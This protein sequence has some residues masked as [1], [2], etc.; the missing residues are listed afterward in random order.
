MENNESQ[1]KNQPPASSDVKPE[2]NTIFETDETSDNKSDSLDVNIEETKKK[3][4]EQQD[5]F[6]I[7]L[8]TYEA[9]DFLDFVSTRMSKID[10]EI[11]K[12]NIDPDNLEEQ[13]NNKDLDDLV[14]KYVKL[15]RMTDYYTDNLSFNKKTLEGANLS[16]NHDKHKIQDLLPH[17]DSDKLKDLAN[18]YS[19]GSEDAL[20]TFVLVTEGDLKNVFLMNS[21]FNVLIRDPSSNELNVLFN[22]LKDES[23]QYG[24]M[25]GSFFYLFS[26]LYIKE[27]IMN[28]IE[29]HIVK[30]NLKGWKKKGIIRKYLSVLDY[31][32]LLHSMVSLMFPDGYDYIYTCPYQ[33]CDYTEEIKIDLNK[34]KYFNLDILPE[35]CLEIVTSSKEFDNKTYQ[36]YQR[37]L[38]FDNDVLVKT[39]K[40]IYKIYLKVPTMEEYL[41]YGKNYNKIMAETIQ[42]GNQEQISNY[43]TYNYLKIFAPWIKK[44]EIINSSTNSILLTITDNDVI[45]T[46]LDVIQKKNKDSL[47]DKIIEFMKNSKITHICYPVNPCPKCKRMPTGAVNGFLPFDIQNNFFFQLQMYLIQLVLQKSP[48]KN[49]STILKS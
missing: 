20:K 10:N 7:A 25:F 15:K 5:L 26:D 4:K 46:I 19:S 37:S 44:I 27:I 30:S 36:T 1:E 9:K 14:K 45:L 35:G 3:I 31:E 12:L 29:N 17:V 32:P 39:T 6:K 22:S 24:R 49:T 43:L 2:D 40:N 38:N 47:S 8:A 33:D 34:L 21:G 11:K 16:F 18:K 42:I 48:E 23:N 41:S 28:F 13:S